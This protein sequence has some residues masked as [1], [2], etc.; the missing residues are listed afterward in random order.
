MEQRFVA[1]REALEDLF[2][3]VLASKEF[4]F[5]PFKTLAVSTTSI[6]TKSTRWRATSR[7]EQ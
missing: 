4:A 1:R 7:Q 5:I 6:P 3:A 2:W